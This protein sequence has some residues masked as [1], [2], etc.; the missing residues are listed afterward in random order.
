[1]TRPCKQRKKTNSLLVVIGDETFLVCVMK[2]RIRDLACGRSHQAKW[3]VLS[4]MPGW[5]LINAL[6]SGSKAVALLS[7]TSDR[8][9]PHSQPS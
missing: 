3:C 6:G 5:V 1:M 9:D 4:S 8:I 2:C 7:V